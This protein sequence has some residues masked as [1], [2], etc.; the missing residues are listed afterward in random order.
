M[1]LSGNETALGSGGGSN[2]AEF[3]DW[4]TIGDLSQSVYTDVKRIRL[5]PLVPR[6][7]PIYR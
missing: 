6:E 5:H 7:I 4:L 2:E 1:H 3:I